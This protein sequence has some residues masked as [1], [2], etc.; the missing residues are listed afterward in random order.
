MKKTFEIMR[1]EFSSALRRKSF[2]LI[3]FGI[4]TIAVIIFAGINLVRSNDSTSSTTGQAQES[5]QFE[6]EGYVDNA[7]IVSSIP[8]DI[9]EGIL[10]PFP[11]EEAAKKALDNGEITAYY[12]IPANYVESG[13]LIYVHPNINPIAEGGQNWVMIWTLYFNLLGG[14]IEMASNV[15]SPANYVRRDLS[16]ISSQDGTSP[17]A[18]TGYTCESNVLIKLLPNLIMVI[19]Y[20]S[21]VSGGSYLLRLVSNEKDSRV[22]ELLLL[23]ASP[24]QLLSGKVVSYCIQNWRSNFK[25]ATWF[26]VSNISPGLGFDFFRAW[27]CDIC[28]N[29]GRSWSS[30]A[31]I[32][33]IYFSLFYSL[34]PVIDQLFIFN[35]ARHETS[36]TFGCGI[37]YFPVICSSHDDNQV[38]CRKCSTLAANSSCCLNNNYGS[39]YHSGSCTH[40]PGTNAPIRSTFLNSTLCESIDELI[41]IGDSE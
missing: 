25:F 14:D 18:C 16:I 22:M 9:P 28:D 35:H 19:I 26:L 5:F 1:Y 13:D 6:I 34:I 23:S 38:N 15:W 37:E 17:E 40:V 27:I 33:S 10:N 36:F 4:P 21:I 41:L 20:I 2:L 32:I 29:D 24:N 39:V 31:K 3:A 7:G 30:N 8:E 12:L 11:S